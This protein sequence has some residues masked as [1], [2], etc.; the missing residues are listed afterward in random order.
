VWDREEVS[1]TTVLGGSDSSGAVTVCSTHVSATTSS[2]TSFAFFDGGSVDWDIANGTTGDTVWGIDDENDYPVLLNAPDVPAF[3]TL[4]FYVPSSGVTLSTTEAVTG[5]QRNVPF[6]L[7]LV[8]LDGDG[9]V[10]AL[11]EASSLSVRVQGG[12]A[13]A[14]V[15]LSDGATEGAAP[16][17]SFEAG[18]EA[19]PVG[20]LVYVGSPTDGTPITLVV[21]GVDGSLSESVVSLTDLEVAPT[22]FAL[23]VGA[24]EALAD[25]S[26]GVTATAT[27]LDASGDG[28]PGIS[29]AFD[30]DLGTLVVSE[31]E[32]GASTTQTTDANGEASVGLASDG[33][34][35]ATLQAACP[36]DCTVEADV[37][38]TGA[39][40][41]V[42]VDVASGTGWV[43]FQPFPEA[44]T[45]VT[46]EVRQDG[47]LVAGSPVT[48]S[49]SDA[50]PP[51]RIGGLEDGVT[52]AVTL[53][54]STDDGDLP[55]SEAVAFT[56]EAAEAPP[57][58]APREVTEDDVEV[59]ENEDGSVDVN[60][61][62]GFTNT[63]GGT[64]ERVWL[65]SDPAATLEAAGIEVAQDAEPRIIEIVTERGDVTELTYEG[66]GLWLWKG[67]GLEEAEQA[68][69]EVLVRIEEA[70]Q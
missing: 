13:D 23:D 24:G 65:M 62:T 17:R 45:A 52:Y 55:A 33:A 14:L 69:F 9:E 21:S 2:A 18:A 39:P 56:P 50:A 19:L 40:S 12:S 32:L 44:V 1:P 5:L 61:T 42:S 64:I 54:G 47:E 53:F 22:T 38:F 63:S 30:T 31:T 58:T 15:D 57:V 66:D 11:E 67:I 29:V 7:P 59:I 46:Y 35:V 10:V 34:G 60:V 27:F 25:G 4:S 16:T 20:D 8:V 3:P 51:I 43:S 49:G 28:I 68:L 26:A 37:A 6:S 41:D 36:G 70:T 48:L